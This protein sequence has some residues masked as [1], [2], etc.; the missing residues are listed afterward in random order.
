MVFFHTS[1]CKSISSLY[2]YR[3]RTI[4]MVDFN[5]WVINSYDRGASLTAKFTIKEYTT[6]SHR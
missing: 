5:I 4:A 3:P 1:N 2:S 6:E